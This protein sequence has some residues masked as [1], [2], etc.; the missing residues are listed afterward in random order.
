ML[1]EYKYDA[2]GNILSQGGSE[3]LT[4]NPFRY[5]GYYYD[6]ETW[7]YYVSAR[8]YDPSLGRW[9]SA[10]NAW[11]LCPIKLNGLNLYSYC[12]NNPIT[13]IDRTGYEPVV[14]SG[15]DIWSL[16]NI[17][18]QVWNSGRY[19]PKFN[20]LYDPNNFLKY[21]G[22][23]FIY[24]AEVLLSSFSASTINWTLKL[25]A[26]TDQ[27]FTLISAEIDVLDGRMYINSSDYL[28][29]K[30]GSA[31]V[32]AGLDWSNE[33]VIGFEAKATALT[34]GAFSKYVD[35]EILI[36][37]VSLTAKFQNGAL[38]LGISIGRGV[39]ITIRFW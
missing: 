38:K 4:I 26:L 34:V 5:R 24:L 1:G 27:G 29:V 32:Q 11:Y 14:N 9:L 6:T 20:Y 25:G 7:L 22:N 3:L 23:N 19:Q 39:E 12:F 21:F 35:A 36:G 10:D 16:L 17:T 33:G 8:Y 18:G 37:S 2:W 31:S 15:I 28:G 13:Y 30:V